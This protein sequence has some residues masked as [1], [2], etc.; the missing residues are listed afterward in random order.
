MNCKEAENLIPQYLDDSMDKDTLL[1][2]MSHI[3]ECR[4]CYN[5]LDTFFMVEKAMNAL[6]QEEER[7][8]DLSKSLEKDLNRK[9]LMIAKNDTGIH[10]TIF[11]AIIVAICMIWMFLDLYGILSLS[12]LL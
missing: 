2:F 9:W 12:Y 6:E 10:L 5:E 7:S 8:F 11:Y 1:E 3:H 4:N